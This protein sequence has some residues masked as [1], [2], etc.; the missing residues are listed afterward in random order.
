M[1]KLAYIFILALLPFAGKSQEKLSAREAVILALEH[2]YSL[3]IA[4]SRVDIAE[5]NNT[6]SEAGLFPTVSLNAGANI[7]LQDNSN[8]PISFVQE[9]I[10]NQNY[11]PSVNLSWNLFSGLGIKITKERLALLEQ[12]SNGN[13]MAEIENI[14][15]EV[16]KAYNSI[17]LEEQKLKVY[18]SVLNYSREQYEY[19]QLKEEYGQSSSLETFQ[20][21]NQLFADSV[22]VIQQ[23]VNIKNAKRNLMV[24]MNV[25]EEMS[26]EQFPKLSDSL[27]APMSAIDQQE[28]ISNLSSNN[29]NLRNQF[30][31]L[32]LQKKMIDY[33]RSFLYPV[34][35]LQAAASPSWGNVRFS[36]SPDQSIGTQSIVYSTGL[37]VRY[38]LFNNYKAKR[39]V[40]VAKIDAEIGEMT[41]DQMQIELENNTLQ[42]FDAYHVQNQLVNLNQ[43]SMRYAQK[44]YELGKAKY[45]QGIINSLELQNLRNNFLN[46]ALSYNDSLFNRMSV[47]LDIYKISGQ[48]QL[49]YNN[50][51]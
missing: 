27:S 1:K 37:N 34:V 2:N 17:L 25:R 9:S 41:Y 43:Q 39:A 48:L 30:L 44:A 5:K 36:G 15:L 47:Y 13:L 14:A 28:V 33:Q 46:A 12:Q 4:Q 3:Q 20:F 45:A 42:L 8:N 35:S 24:L 10:I 6:W 11:N 49:S 21:R 29:Q 23:E 22:N 32:E 26:L 31:A 7:A 18:K 19:Y 51:N 50:E 38:N 40:E 16:L